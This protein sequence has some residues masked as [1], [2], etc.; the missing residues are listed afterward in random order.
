MPQSSETRSP[1]LDSTDAPRYAFPS[2]PCCTSGRAYTRT[3]KTP[4]P[5]G[6]QGVYGSV[7]CL[8][9]DARPLFPDRRCRRLNSGYAAGKAVLPTLYTELSRFLLLSEALRRRWRSPPPSHRPDGHER[10]PHK[11]N[12]QFS[13]FFCDQIGIFFQ[14]FLDSAAKFFYR[15]NLIFEC[16][17]CFST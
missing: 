4:Q 12:R 7:R 3:G 11:H 8:C 17:C 1:S 15:G 13:C 9:S 6:S 16:D 14:R 10:P 5:S 2:I